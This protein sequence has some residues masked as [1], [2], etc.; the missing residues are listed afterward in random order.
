MAKTQR[1]A[2]FQCESHLCQ[3]SLA[4]N[5]P[6]AYC[7]VS[8]F[9][10]NLSVCQSCQLFSCE[11][12]KLPLASY[13][14][15][16]HLTLHPSICLVSLFRTDHFTI[17]LSI[18]LASYFRADHLTLHLHISLTIYFCY[19]HPFIGMASNILLSIHLRFICVLI[20]IHWMIV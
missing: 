9:M 6:S 1:S 19:F 7:S 10:S 16:V 15:A 13:F 4:P 3:I 8:H 5:L 18:T 2:N 17:H 12:F 20:V 11:A 14:R